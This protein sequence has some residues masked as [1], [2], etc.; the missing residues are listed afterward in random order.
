[1][2]NH[3]CPW[4]VGHL[5]MCPLRRW[6]DNPEKLLS[7]YVKAGMTVLDIGAGMGYFSIPAAR[8][9]GAGGRKV[10]AVDS[11]EKMLSNLSNGHQRQ[12]LRTAYGLTC[13]D[14]T[15]WAWS[16]RWTFASRS[17]WCT[18][19]PTHGAYWRKSRRCSGRLVS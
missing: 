11:Q 14:P 2:G 3:V 12:A 1:M 7:P 5:L 9:V 8:M 19:S 10:I 6:V 13:A 17:M 15:P 4:W 18:K 16:S